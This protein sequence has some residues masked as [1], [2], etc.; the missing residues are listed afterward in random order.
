MT[1]IY[2]AEGYTIRDVINLLEEVGRE[3]GDH[4]PICVY[5]HKGIARENI[6]VYFGD[7]STNLSSEGEEVSL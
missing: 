2:R 7:I 5:D 1:E 6:M 3:L 4:I